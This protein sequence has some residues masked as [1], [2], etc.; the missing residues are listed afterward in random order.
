MLGAGGVGTAGAAGSANVS[1]VIG[2]FPVYLYVIARRFADALTFWDTAPEIKSD[3][4]SRR[5]SARVAIQVLAGQDAKAEAEE[6]RVLLEKQLSERPDD[7]FGRTELAWVYLALGRK[8][9][10]LRL[11]REVADLLPIEMDAILGAT[12]QIG[13]NRGL[14]GPTRARDEPAPTLTLDSVRHLY[15]PPKD[16]PSV[17]SDP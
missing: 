9:D 17:G 16:R 8:A 14:V 5:L 10:A 4:H 12:A 1:V 15:C 7:L 2:G 3:P 6:A 13:L 11:S